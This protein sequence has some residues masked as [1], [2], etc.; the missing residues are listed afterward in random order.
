MLWSILKSS[1]DNDKI[2]RTDSLIFNNQSVL[3]FQEK[4]EVCYR[5]FAKQ[6]TIIET[7][8]NFPTKILR[9]ANKSLN[10]II[11]TQDDI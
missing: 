11:F 7:G 1:F 2:S 10:T 6:S 8:R 4:R 5:F 3:D 9:G